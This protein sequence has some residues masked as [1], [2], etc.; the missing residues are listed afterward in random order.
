MSDVNVFYMCRALDTNWR[1]RTTRFVASYVHHP[2][3]IDH[4][5]TV[6]FKEFETPD[7]LTWAKKQFDPLEADEIID[8]T[9]AVGNG[10][11]LIACS[12]VREPIMCVLASS[13]EI[14]QDD[15]LLKMYNALHLSNVG[16]V[17]CC[18]SDAFIPEW[19]PGLTYPNPHIR[20]PTFMIWRTLFQQVA[21]SFDF[22]TK[23][24]DCAFEHGPNSMTKQ[25]LALGKE[26]LVVEKERTVGPPWSGTTYLGNLQNV[27]VHDRGARS[28][29]DL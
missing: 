6:I 21:G 17:G 29:H 22:S 12:F 20:T 8:P 11:F 28:Y 24:D 27:L 19:F 14:M 25:V 9:I 18:G 3:G 7:D 2:A 1:A 5:L 13:A 4:Q 15:W 16:L 10:S 26:V 23:K